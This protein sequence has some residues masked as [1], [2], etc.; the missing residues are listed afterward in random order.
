MDLDGGAEDLGSL[1]GLR[2]EGG[3][4]A[5]GEG[6]QEWRRKEDNQEKISWRM[7]KRCQKP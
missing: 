4:L 7:V 6:V 2:E 3:G 5:L 1:G